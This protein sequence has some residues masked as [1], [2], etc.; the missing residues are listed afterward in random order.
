MIHLG[1]PLPLGM[2]SVGADGELERHGGAA[3]GD[4]QNM[5][6]RN[7]TRLLRQNAVLHLDTR[8][9]KPLEPEPGGARVGVA[10]RNHGAGRP[11]RGDELGASEPPSVQMGARFERDKDGGAPRTRAGVLEGD[12][13]GVGPPARRGPA[14][15]KNFP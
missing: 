5:P 11:G 13:F 12:G 2:Q 8:G 7:F 3:F 10:Q 4:A 14:T 9:L 1:A 6:E 15:G